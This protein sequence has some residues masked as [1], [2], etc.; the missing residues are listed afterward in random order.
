MGKCVSNIPYKFLL[1]LNKAESVGKSLGWFP[2]EAFSW[3]FNY[4]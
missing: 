3:I 1:L 4:E 2:Q